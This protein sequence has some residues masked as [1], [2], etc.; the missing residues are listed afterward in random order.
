MELMVEAQSVRHPR[1]WF[2]PLQGKGLEP[3]IRMA[4][5]YLDS[6]K[7]TGPW[8]QVYWA[9]PSL[10]LSQFGGI[11]LGLVLSVWI[12]D[13][14]CAYDEIIAIGQCRTDRD[15]TLIE[16]PA[17]DAGLQAVLKLG[18]RSRKSCL[19]LPET[20]AEGAKQA[21]RLAQVQQLGVATFRAGSLNGAVDICLGG[22]TRA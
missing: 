3:A 8:P 14:R 17:T 19:I 18:A 21:E 1:P 13:E 10:P 4:Q 2:F 16:G 12:A 5:Q 22:A 11:V 15:P 9:N 20:G 7:P 6:R